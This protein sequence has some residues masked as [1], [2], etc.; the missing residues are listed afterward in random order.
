MIQFYAPD[1]LET[2]TLPESDS[3]HAIKV[4]RMQAGDELQVIDGRGNCYTCRIA[5][6]DRKR[7]RVEIVESRPMPLPWPQQ[8]VLAVAP[9]KHIDRMEWAVEKVTEIGVNRIIPVVADRSE[10]RDLKVER[11]ERIAVSAMKQSLKGVLPRIDPLTPV[12]DVIDGFKEYNRFIAY[13]DRSIP[14]LLLARE[15]QPEK[16]TI[17]LIGPEGDFSPEEIRSALDSSWKPVSLGPCRLRTETAAI[18]AVD[19]CHIIDQT[20]QS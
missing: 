6:P 10:R 3:G 11:L 4:L 12:M 14:R 2:L 20:V 17:I 18:V 1:I 5:A 15:Y 16:N 9:T 19:T 13:C 8:I 7:T